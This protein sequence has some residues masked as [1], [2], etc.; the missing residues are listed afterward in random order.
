[1]QKIKQI[2]NFK[3]LFDNFWVMTNYLEI[4]LM[5]MLHIQNLWHF[6]LIKEK[7]G[8]YPQPPYYYYFL[9]CDHNTYNGQLII[10]AQSLKLCGVCTVSGLNFPFDSTNI[11][12]KKKTPYK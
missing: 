5:T 11:K 7:N 3:T 10:Q 1:M 6:F 4:F 8:N 2:F 12:K 9:P